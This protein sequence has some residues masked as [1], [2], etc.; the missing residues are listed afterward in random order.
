MNQRLF[1]ALNRLFDKHRIVFWYDAEKELR[2]EY[3]ALSF[4]DVEKIELDANEFQVKYRVLREAPT[5]KFLLFHEGER[6]VDTGNWL[7]DV[8]LAQAQFSTDQLGMW[9]SELELGPEFRDLVAEHFDFFKA[10]S[11]R[12]TLKAILKA[13]DSLGKTRLKMIGVCLKCEPRVDVILEALLNELAN[14]QD[15]GSLLLTKFKLDDHLWQQAQ[16]L[17]AYHTEN[18]G[19]LDFALELFKS[20]YDRMLDGTPKLNQD[21]SILLQRWK[22][23]IT[24]RW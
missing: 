6:P 24:G 23:W 4:D 21:A 18:P 15:K 14:G 7:L 8:L 10:G 2:A 17:Y 12:E 11:R 5:Q 22:P 9:L 19:P 20:A 13:N 3:E 1:T 16:G